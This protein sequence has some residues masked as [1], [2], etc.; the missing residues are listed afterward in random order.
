MLSLEL[1]GVL[2]VLYAGLVY[3]LV[4]TQLAKREA[5]AGREVADAPLAAAGKGR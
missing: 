1:I 5:A 4:R 2:G 3:A